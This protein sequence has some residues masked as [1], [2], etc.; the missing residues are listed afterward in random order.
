MAL[1][2]LHDKENVS[3]GVIKE[4][5]NEIE[6]TTMMMEGEQ[7]VLALNPDTK[8][9]KY[10]KE[11]LVQHDVPIE[12][13]QEVQVDREEQMEKVVSPLHDNAEDTCDSPQRE[14]KLTF[15]HS[16]KLKADSILQVDSWIYNEIMGLKKKVELLQQN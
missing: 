12:N 1:I 6:N 9:G 8:T 15:L 3:E 11:D 10:D 14:N 2:L 16:A 13:K 5:E 7:M 4:K